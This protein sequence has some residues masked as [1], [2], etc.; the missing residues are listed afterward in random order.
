M[1]SAPKLI[2]AA[3]IRSATRAALVLDAEEQRDDERRAERDANGEEA[4]RAVRVAPEERIQ[5]DLE[6]PGS[7]EDGSDR[8]RPPAGVVERERRQDDEEPEQHRRERVQPQAAEE[9]YVAERPSQ[10]RERHRLPGRGAG[11]R[12][13]RL[14]R[15]A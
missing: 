5:D 1:Y 10:A 15:R 6:Q 2:A 13:E 11:E 4:T 9:A 7:K 3:Q 12:G 8:E 14:R